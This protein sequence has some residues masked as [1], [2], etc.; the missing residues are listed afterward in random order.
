VTDGVN[1][2]GS[3][4]DTAGPTLL[5]R[6]EALG[7]PK[8]MLRRGIYIYAGEYIWARFVARASAEDH[9][10]AE[11]ALVALGAGRAA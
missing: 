11:A 9:A 5:E 10:A 6:A 8:L 2:T 7:Y 4:A 3:A 1:T